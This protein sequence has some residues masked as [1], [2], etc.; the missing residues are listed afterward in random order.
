MM[1]EQYNS[2]FFDGK[3]FSEREDVIA[4]EV[5]LSISINGIP[6]TVT[7]QTPGHEMDLTTGLLFTEGIFTDTGLKPNIEII[8]RN[9]DGFINSVNV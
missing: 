2:I 9:D 6:F 5:A 3:N 4:I 8:S 7:M 1:T